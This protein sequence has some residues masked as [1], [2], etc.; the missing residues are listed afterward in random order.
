MFF[1]SQ[2]LYIILHRLLQK[3]LLNSHSYP[4]S[5]ETELKD[6]CLGDVKISTEHVGNKILTISAPHACPFMMVDF[7]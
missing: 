1:H 3:C 7:C 5:T 2:A 4:H 6:Q